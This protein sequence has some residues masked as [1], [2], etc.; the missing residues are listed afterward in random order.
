M[1]KRKTVL[2]ALV[3]VAAV[4]YA[5]AWVI[6]ASDD[7][8]EPILAETAGEYMS[9]TA[10]TAKVKSALLADRSTSGLAIQVETNK[11]VV[12]LSGFVNS[13]AEMQR[14]AEIARGVEG[15]TEV[16]NDI[17]VGGKVAP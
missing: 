15:V 16:K 2:P 5:G 13:E 3:A 11:G 14:A 4:G 7:P 6:A 10:I 12:Q 1:I 9:D 8:L 17:R